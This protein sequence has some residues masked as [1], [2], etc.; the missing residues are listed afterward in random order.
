MKNAT[1]HRTKE[2]LLEVSDLR[3][4]FDTYGGIVKAV[5]G[6]SFEVARGETLAIVGESGCGKSVTV[7]SLMGL[8]PM[9]P[10]RI[11]SGFVKLKGQDILGVSLEKAN[12]FRGKEIGMIFQDP[13]TSLNPTMTVGK[14]IAETV[15]VH[16]G[17]SADE[18]RKRAIELLELVQIPEAKSRV[19][20][21][22]F[23]FSGGMR[24]RV[25]I[26]MAIACKPSVLIADEPTT[27]LDVTIQAQI[28]RLLRE[29]Q[30]ERDMAIILITHDLGVVAQMADKV[31]V[32]YAGQIV[33]SGTVDEIFYQSGHPYTLGLR[34]AMP[35][36][37]EEKSK[38]LIPIEGAPPDLFNPP[39][40]CSYF[41][42]CPNAMKIC[43]REN[44]ALFNVSSPEHLSR[45]WLQVPR[46]AQPGGG[47]MRKSLRHTLNTAD[48]ADAAAE[49]AAE[50]RVTFFEQPS[51]PFR[52]DE[53]GM[54]P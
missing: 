37:D 5:R 25:M 19:D 8:I 23:Q 24:Q 32:M 18:G 13:M 21:Y 45:C 7:Q 38:V 49:T 4:E 51:A 35:E 42:R 15:R 12:Q 54:A 11:T 53:S 46:R 22:P 10:G 48:A 9:P 50:G 28:L 30:R 40:G 36:N 43:G 52:G 17:V 14:Q 47:G 6:V 29:L 39:V 2:T 16:D 33:E 27:A 3:V 34:S 31:A 20:H 1:N 44:P 41:E 26:A